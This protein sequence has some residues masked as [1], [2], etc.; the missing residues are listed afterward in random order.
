MPRKL[1]F[2]PNLEPKADHDRN[3]E[4][5]SVST[6]IVNSS[7]GPDNLVTQTIETTKIVRK[8]IVESEATYD[9]STL[10]GS[11]AY[12]HANTPTSAIKPGR[13]SLPAYDTR[14]KQSSSDD[15]SN[16]DDHG[17]HHGKQFNT[18]VKGKI[19]PRRSLDT[20]SLSAPLRSR[21][22]K[23]SLANCGQF[24]VTSGYSVPGLHALSV[25]SGEWVTM[26]GPGSSENMRIVLN[27]SA[28][29]GEV[30][31]SILRPCRTFAMSDDLSALCEDCRKVYNQFI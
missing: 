27:A 13:R 14:E 6:R 2:N 5:V 9:H 25:V 18:I 7:I 8:S 10:R 11:Q 20:L 4:S 16:P 12:T 3:D 22:S 30:P 29:Q 26:I 1:S 28:R 23:L 15:Q 19:E 31:V 24:Q 17:S 21:A